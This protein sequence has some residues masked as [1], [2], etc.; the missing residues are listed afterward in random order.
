MPS[1]TRE[2]VQDR[3]SLG[4]AHPGAPHLFVVLEASRPSAGGAR[5]ALEGVREVVVV[6]GD[7]RSFAVEGGV[8]VLTLPS[9]SA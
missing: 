2:T 4:V 6:R 3:S 1:T 9:P 7:E 8:A 5:Y